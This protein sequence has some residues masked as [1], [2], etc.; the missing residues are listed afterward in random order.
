M[1]SP[2]RMSDETAST[3]KKKEKES[4]GW[5]EWIRGW[6]SVF[7][8]ILFQRITASHYLNPLPLPPVNGLPCIVTGS[9]SGIGRETARLGIVLVPLLLCSQA[10]CGGWCTCCD[11][12]EEHEGS[13]GANSA[14]A[15]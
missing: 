3:K 15:E 7:G 10:A 5:M 1:K 13:S 2:S 12:C 9:T 14:M 6:S 4:L 8:E 11:G